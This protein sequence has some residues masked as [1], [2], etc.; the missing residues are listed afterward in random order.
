MG[1]DSR[2]REVSLKSGNAVLKALLELGYDARALDFTYENI[3][4][5][6]KI[7]PDLAFMALH[8]K[9]GEDG[10]AQG[11]MELLRIPY[12]GSGVAAS[13][14]C[15]NK[16]LTKK[17][18]R[19]A[20]L[21]SPDFLFFRKR[22]YKINPPSA[23]KIAA[24]LGLPLVI[25]AVSQGS[26]IGTFIV[27]K[28]EEILPAMAQAFELDDEVVAEKFIDGPL[29]TVTVLGNEEPWALPIIEIISSNDFYDYDSKYTEGASEHIIP[30]NISEALRKQV[31]AICLAAYKEAGCGGLARIDVMVDTNDNPYILEINTMPGM[32]ATSLAPDAARAAGMSF[33]ELVQLI[34]ELS[35]EKPAD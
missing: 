13:A 16:L 23:E 24:R 12:T 33:N 4:E 27:R 26:S 2:E 8:G 25:K 21:P 9:Y 3:N 32:T 1:G 7:K 20:G 30:S 18:L 15:M 17:M 11:Y 19:Q 5:I 6:N 22:E 14:V 34:I 10:C 29:L 31:E 35:E 28:T